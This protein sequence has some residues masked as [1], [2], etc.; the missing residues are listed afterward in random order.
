[1]LAAIRACSWVTVVLVSVVL[2]ETGCRRAAE[3]QAT[4]SLGPI[5]CFRIADAMGISST[6]AIQLCA[7]ATSVAPGQCLAA[8]IDRGVLTTQQMVQLCREATSNASFECFDQLSAIGTLTNNQM[9]EYCGM[10][11][12]LGPPP[13]EAGNAECLAT[14]LDRGNLSHQTAAEL[15]LLAT[16]AGPVDCFVAGENVTQLPNSQLI[17]LCAKTRSCQYVNAPATA[18]Y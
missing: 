15:C 3:A 5:E 13:P 14:A 6:S 17:Q 12:P 4:D 2:S 8:A 1:M 18:A 9:I 16:S 7:G 11:C 10:R